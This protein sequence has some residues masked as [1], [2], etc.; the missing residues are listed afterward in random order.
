MARNKNTVKTP[1]GHQLIGKNQKGS[2]GRSFNS[3]Y[4][5]GKDSPVRKKGRPY[6]S[7]LEKRYRYTAMVRK[8]NRIRREREKATLIRAEHGY[9]EKIPV[10]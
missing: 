8:S 9:S 10:T 5:K 4:Q 3:N 7:T 6:K 2:G 1:I